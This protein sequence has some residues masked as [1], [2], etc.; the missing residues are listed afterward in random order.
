MQN[1]VV[2]F[3]YIVEIIAAGYAYCYDSIDIVFALCEM[4]ITGFD[5]TFVGGYENLYDIIFGFVT[6]FV[7]FGLV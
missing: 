5:F 1:P 6:E 3:D 4:K 2:L 7:G